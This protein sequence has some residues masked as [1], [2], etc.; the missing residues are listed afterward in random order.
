MSTDALQR[1]VKAEFIMIKIAAS[2]PIEI[3]LIVTV[4]EIGIRVN[5]R[6]QALG[7]GVVIG[8]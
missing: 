3:G 4:T 2:T 6:Q 5:I 7:Q 8:T 1:R